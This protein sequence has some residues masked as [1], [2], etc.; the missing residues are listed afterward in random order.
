MG[1]RFIPSMIEDPTL[2]ELSPSQVVIFG[3]I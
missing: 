1:E 3:Y 2:Y